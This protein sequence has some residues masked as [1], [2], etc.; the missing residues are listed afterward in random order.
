MATTYTTAALRDG[1]RTAVLERQF[2][3]LDVLLVATSAVVAL[4]LVLVYAGRVRL[5]DL[6]ESSRHD[7][8][9]VN[10]NTVADAAPLD[11]ALGA[12][13]TDPNER[14]AA[15]GELFRFLGE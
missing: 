3:L 9:V 13:F 4:A 12:A 11:A 6:S 1:R 8:A 2:G 5:L 14:R 15:A 10:L 7:G